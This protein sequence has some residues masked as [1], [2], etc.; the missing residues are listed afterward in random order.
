MNFSKK[1]LIR[2]L[3]TPTNR[4]RDREHSRAKPGVLCECIKKAIN[5]NG[6]KKII[7]NRAASLQK[8]FLSIARLKTSLDRNFSLQNNLEIHELKV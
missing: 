3:G 4:N 8:T 5:I 6:I 2:N 7:R 1:V